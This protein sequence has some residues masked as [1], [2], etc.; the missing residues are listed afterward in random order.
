MIG[1]WGRLG[2]VAAALTLS[3]AAVVVAAAPAAAG[4]ATGATQA[5]SGVSAH[6][7]AG[8]SDATATKPA[9]VTL[10]VAADNGGVLKPGIDLVVSAMISNS[11]S[12]P[13]DAGSISVWLADGSLTTRDALSDWSDGTDRPDGVRSLGTATAGRVEPGSTT[14]VRITVPST[15]VA[16]TRDRAAILPLGASLSAGTKAVASGHG[17]LLWQP[18]DAG[19]RT[20]LAIAMP[21]TVPAGSK[22]LISAADL[23]T[24][25][26]ANG[27]LSRQIDG[28]DG[29]PDVAIGL[30]PMILASIR[31]LGSSAPESA[32]EW[33]Q[34]LLNLPNDV[35]PLQ[36]GDAD[37]AGE[38][39]AGVTELLKPTS[40]AWAMKPSDFQ[41]PPDHVGETP[42]ATSKAPASP[43]PTPTSTSG[44]ALPTLD[45][46]LSWPYT[47]SGIVWPAD[48]TVRAADLPVF[49]ANGLK[50]TIVSGSNTSMGEVKT[51]PNAAFSAGDNTVIAADDAVSNAL[52]SAVGAT[53]PTAWNRAMSQL[54]AE[55][56][57]V[58]QEKGPEARTILATLSRGW[59]ADS[60][61]L[62]LTLDALA[63]AP[64]VSSVSLPAALDA[65]P[66]PGV[67]I[68]DAPETAQHV[69][70]IRQ[71]LTTEKNLN[72]FATL[73]DDPTTLTGPTRA[74]LL[75]LLGVS[76][77][78]AQNDWPSA[79]AANTKSSAA[80]LDSVKIVPASN[81]NVFSTEAPIPV[82]VENGFSQRVN[83]VLQTRP[84]NARLEIDGN[85]TQTVQAD[86]RAT[87]RVPVKANL[88]NG[89]VKLYLQLYS[90][91]GVAIGDEAS[92][93]VEV[94]AE[95]EGVVALALAIIVVGLF[96]FGIVRNLLRHRAEKRAEPHGDG[97]ADAGAAAPE[98][99]VAADASTPPE[100]GASGG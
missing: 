6:A 51:T 24:Y 98:N 87:M 22:G 66:T 50:T 52:R 10:S 75:A 44:P 84:S 67:T 16:L 9:A 12:A 33:R 34:K 27:L 32:L 49:A 20:N 45:E 3:V 72:A 95:W 4:A 61:R 25:T 92:I 14:T 26:A 91:T 41:A 46:L 85:A 65:A 64:W 59:P 83:L 18:A 35:F 1:H 78:N 63:S 2:R 53:S 100:D 71:L 43:T 73:L 54:G 40:L 74:N 57:L 81:V 56:E 70:G 7:A 86:S 21:I 31:V 80:I 55:L 29:H 89:K 42:E 62:S 99:A 94:H 30:D 23:A 88:G 60:L 5:A 28:L 58:G 76:W 38:V 68:K 13:V 79:L 77:F 93:P 15:A 69:A 37:A 47:M 90:P 11:G 97:E 17:A 96:G 8:A 82:T 19:K 36:Y 39:Q 48:G